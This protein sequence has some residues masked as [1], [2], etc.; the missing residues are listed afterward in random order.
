MS[1][2]PVLW[3]I[4]LHYY[5][6]LSG[7]S[8][9]LVVDVFICDSG[10]NLKDLQLVELVSYGLGSDKR[11]P[12]S[13]RISGIN[14]DL[15]IWP[16]FM[17]QHCCWVKGLRSIFG[18]CFF[19]CTWRGFQSMVLER[20]DIKKLINDLWTRDATNQQKETEKTVVVDFFF[21]QTDTYI[22]I[23]KS[24]IWPVSFFLLNTWKSHRLSLLW[25]GGC[26]VCCIPNVCC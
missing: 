13:S 2:D 22:L 18:L 6:G 24:D 20:R 21:L 8:I 1:W 11:K 9:V 14:K 16:M 25:S 23:L 3:Y 7:L 15:G 19:C 17:M 12:I 26:C 4:A 5:Q 10:I